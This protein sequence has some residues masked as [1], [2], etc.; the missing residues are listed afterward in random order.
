[1]ASAPRAKGATK[2]SWQ[3]TD[4]V[5]QQF[6]RKKNT[7][8]FLMLLSIAHHYNEKTGQSFPSIERSSREV[9]CSQ[10]W[11]IKLRGKLLGLGDIL[12]IEKGRGRG[13][14]S[15]FGLH[16]KYAEKVNSITSPFG[17]ERVNSGNGKG[18]LSCARKG[19]QCSRESVGESNKTKRKQAVAA[20]AVAEPP[21]PLPTE[22]DLAAEARLKAAFKE[23]YGHELGANVNAAR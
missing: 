16:Q 14:P 1:M 10:R 23:R 21:P 20:S 2:V 18:E 22:E 9:G 5:F 4:A 13:H 15:V 8:E 7:R 17:K 12:L 6:G 19:E 3:A 11:A